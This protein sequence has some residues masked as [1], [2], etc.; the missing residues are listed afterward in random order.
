MRILLLN[1]WY[2]SGQTTHVDSL[3]CA[4]ARL[5]HEVVL[6]LLGVRSAEQAARLFTAE[7]RGNVRMVARRT[8]LDLYNELQPLEPDVIH[9]HSTSTWVLGGHLAEGTSAPLVVTSHGLGIGSF[10][11]RAVASQVRAVV[12]PGARTAEM[13]PRIFGSQARV[14]VIDNGIDL[15]HFVPKSKSATPRVVY[16]G[17]VDAGRRL[18]FDIFR[19]VAAKLSAEVLVVGTGPEDRSGNGASSLGWIRDSA[20]VLREADIVLGIGRS[21]RE[22]L[23]CGAVGV[24]L[25]KSYHGIVTPERVAEAGIH[26]MDFVDFERLPVIT[27]PTRLADALKHDLRSLLSDTGEL[28]RLQRFSR[29]FAVGRLDVTA[30]AHAHA[31]LYFELTHVR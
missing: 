6:G 16:L 19:G 10:E 15:E 3:A 13:A 27:D 24:V 22:A 12:C 4:L 28:R 20:E 1:R 18:G 11:E 9:A 23:A 29:E 21:L 5:G 2:P 8:M 25:G 31:S 14:H 30:R 7:A 17:R 26:E